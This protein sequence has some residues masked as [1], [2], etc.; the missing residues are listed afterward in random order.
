M[1]AIQFSKTGGP[2]VLSYVDVE[3]PTPGTG[4]VLIKV[5][6]SAVNFGDIAV[7]RGDLPL[8]NFPATPGLEYS[9]T[10]EALGENVPHLQVGQRVV[11]QSYLH[12]FELDHV[13]GGYAEYAVTT[14]DTVVPLPD[15]IDFDTAAA[16]FCNYLAAYFMLHT[17]AR[18]KAG[19]TLLLHGAAGGIG[20]A[21]LQ[22][23]RLDGIQVIGLVSS[24]QRMTY[25]LEQGAYAV[26]NYRDE[27]VSQR[28]LELTGNRGVDFIFNS[29]GGNTLSRD[30]DLLAPLGQIIWFGFAAGAPDSDLTALITDFKNFAKGK[31][32]RT[33][34]LPSY[35]AKPGLWQ[36]ASSTIIDY[37]RKGKIQPHIH[38]T[39]SLAN[40]IDAHKLMEASNVMGK[41]LLKP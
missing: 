36:Q 23:A 29:T 6:R 15:D 5:A 38:E 25:V 8:P 2:D 32:I 31:G 18:V 11:I 41:L 34:A 3:R 39:I 30:Y 19:E 22:L 4:Q 24:P 27:N 1:K 10:I 20:T 17:Q 16:L 14:A 13:G 40:A 9:G 7:R 28:V 21:V 26:I 35:D 33:S 12:V 37:F